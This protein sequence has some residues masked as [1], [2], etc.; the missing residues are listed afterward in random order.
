MYKLYPI[1]ALCLLNV[2][3]AMTVN[4]P[5]E[6]TKL[7][8]NISPKEHCKQ[9]FAHRYIKN[10]Y[11]SKARARNIDQYMWRTADGYQV[12]E[13]KMWV[14]FY[15]GYGDETGSIICKIVDKDTHYELYGNRVSHSYSRLTPSGSVRIY[16][17][18]HII[19]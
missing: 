11:R 1:L 17:Y 3:C 8:H 6:P 9:I 13:Y 4:Q 10:I 14:S 19:K 16:D 12:Y 5:Y 15:T 7:D 2:G 18:P